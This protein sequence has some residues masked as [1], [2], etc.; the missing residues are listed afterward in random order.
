MEL[1][2]MK[3]DPEAVLHPLENLG[4]KNCETKKAAS[5]RMKKEDRNIGWLVNCKHSKKRQSEVS[6]KS[7]S[8]HRTVSFPQRVLEAE[9][10]P[11]RK[12][13]F[14]MMCYSILCTI[15]SG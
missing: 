12:T 8:Y 2:E 15:E 14:A 4:Q 1:M 10:C 5:S 7:D 3:D 11:T 6:S 13:V 9:Q